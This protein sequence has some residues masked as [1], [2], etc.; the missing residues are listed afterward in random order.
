MENLTAPY[1]WKRV[2][3]PRGSTCN[4]YFWNT[5]IWLTIFR[6]YVLQISRILNYQLSHA[7]HR[8]HSIQNAY[9]CLTS[10]IQWHEQRQM[11]P[12]PY[13]HHCIWQTQW[14]EQTT[15][16]LQWT[17]GMSFKGWCL[18]RCFW[19]DPFYWIMVNAILLINSLWNNSI[20]ISHV[21]KANSEWPDVHHGTFIIENKSIKMPDA[22]RPFDSFGGNDVVNLISPTVR[23]AYIHWW[24]YLYS[25]G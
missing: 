2:N 24:W 20:H 22:L 9:N 12:F 14:Y 8:G 4:L 1:H 7:R 6:R 25:D 19:H 17:L 11:T 21:S 5:P 15:V 3:M 13:I 10:I 16:N 18:H 23:F